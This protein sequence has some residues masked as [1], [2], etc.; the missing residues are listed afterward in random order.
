MG[1]SFITGKLI[2]TAAQLPLLFVAKGEVVSTIYT[3]EELQTQAATAK[4][5]FA[6]TTNI[7]QLWNCGTATT[8]GAYSHCGDGLHCI[9]PVCVGG[10][11][12][13]LFLAQV[14][15]APWWLPVEGAY[16]RQ[17]EGKDSNLKGR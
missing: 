5:H 3:F 14:A 1:G 15:Q 13:Y 9:W 11:H 17:P 4:V 2:F 16:W 7:L 12:D 8:E 10:V 6:A